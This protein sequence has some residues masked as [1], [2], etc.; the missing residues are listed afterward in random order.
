MNINDIICIDAKGYVYFNFIDPY[1]YKDY[2]YFIGVQSPIEPWPSHLWL[3]K[4]KPKNK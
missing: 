3:I 1:R 2:D 4:L